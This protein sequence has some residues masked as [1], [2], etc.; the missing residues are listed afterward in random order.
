MQTTLYLRPTEVSCLVWI[1]FSFLH[2]HPLDVQ[3][4]SK[5]PKIAKKS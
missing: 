4:K 1:A 2:M 5:S 3:I